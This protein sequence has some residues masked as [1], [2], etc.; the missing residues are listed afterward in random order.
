MISCQD[1]QVY[2]IIFPISHGP[3]GSINF[4]LL[5]KGESITLIDAGIDNQTCWDYF[6]IVLAEHGFKTTDIDRIV[7]THHHEDHVGLLRRILAVKDIPIYAHPITILR[8][9][10]DSDFFHMRYRFFQTLYTEMDCILDAQ[11]RLEKLKKTLNELDKKRLIA[12]YIPIT[13]GDFVGE[14]EVIETPGHS[15]DS[16]SLYDRKRQ[17]L[18]TGDLVLKDSS[19]NAIIDPDLNG[20]RLQ[21]VTQQRQSL[22]K[23]AEL[24]AKLVF[25][26]HRSIIENHLQLIAQKIESM[27]RKVN[28]ILIYLKQAQS[29]SSLAK[30][31]YQSK[32]NSEF[33]LVMSEII[34]YLDYLENLQLVTKKM[35]NGVWIY[36]AI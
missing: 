31:Y 8:L 18:F 21:S 5:K 29:A 30:Q 4:F 17:W 19:T 24:D 11:S 25:P 36:N 1:Q 27:D 26:G 9:K 23:C 20:V 12:N 13:A 10:M 6:N 28:R 15:P 7:L 22:L 34:G 3:L 32:Y 35:K 16:I 33:S 2:P 14:F